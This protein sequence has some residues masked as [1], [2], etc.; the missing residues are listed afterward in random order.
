MNAR[1]LH[2]SRKGRTSSW[3]RREKRLAIYL[4]DG[5][6]CSY[7]GTDLRGARP[8]DMGLDHLESQDECKG[9]GNCTRSGKSMNHESNL[10]LACR[11][12]NS[13]RQ[14]MP[15]RQFA[16][17]GAVDRILRN[18]RRVLNMELARAIVRG[19]ASWSDA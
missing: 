5:V 12:C 15:W 3:I 2:N 11:S 19:D 17:G 18:R 9:R 1:Q 4:R 16:T 8:C 7:C 10:V 13:S 6:H 14:S